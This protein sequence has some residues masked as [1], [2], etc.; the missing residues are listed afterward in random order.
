MKKILI[1]LTLCFAVIQITAQSYEETYLK[2]EK[3]RL[4]KVALVEIE[5][6]NFITQNINTFDFT[7]VINSV[8]TTNKETG[9]PL[10][11][12]DYAT[13]LNTAK[14]QKLRNEYFKK[15]PEKVSLYFA[16]V[17]QQ[18][19]N[20]G[21]EDNGGSTAGYGFASDVYDQST[22]AQYTLTPTTVVNPAP[23]SNV[24]L[25]DAGS[26]DPNIP[27]IP[28]V[29]SGKYAIRLNQPTS[30]LSR[31][32]SLLRRQFIVNERSISYAYAL[33]FQNPADGG[34]TK[35]TRYPY[36]QVRLKNSSGNIVYQRTVDGVSNPIFNYNP[37]NNI[38]Y[39]GWR[40]ENIDTSQYM[41]QF[42]TLEIIMSNCG[43]SGH[44]GYGYFDDFCGLPPN[45]NIPSVG[46]I[47]L[48]PR[49]QTGCPEDPMYITGNYQLPPNATFQMP[50]AGIKLD[51]LEAST[52]N[53]VTTLTSP[54]FPST[55][56]FSFYVSSYS[57]YPSGM[58]SNTEFNFRVR[59]IYNTGG[60]NQ[61]EVSANH[62]NPPGPDV[63]FKNCNSP[64]FEEMYINEK[65]VTSQT[66][67]ASGGIYASSQIY[68]NLEVTYRAGYQ[69]QL[70][71]GFYATG[72]D[73][74][75]FHAY[76]GPCED[77]NTFTKIPPVNSMAKAS[78]T[79]ILPAEIKIHPNPASG[80]FKISTGSEKL[81]SWEM[82]DLSGKMV[83]KG[84]T[85][86]ANVQNLLKGNY[87]LKINLE[88]RQV[89]KT[90]ILK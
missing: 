1:L 37:S 60:I 67:Q 36:Y 35:D 74:G 4:D 26:A 41:G 9:Q 66:F 24:T 19:T 33:F 31:R 65:V 21:F 8:D 45:C 51:I 64:C 30:V 25:V 80:Y 70:L 23:N 39:S 49:S 72:Q 75:I 77:N 40:C 34:H 56:N 73:V 86:D 28:R 87:F 85:S 7:T 6:E 29:Y 68:P 50:G 81:L 47:N 57:F 3:K 32:A 62:T 12:S 43:N 11:A 15:N 38:L 53:L 52:G 5:I 88:K 76:I 42:V 78:E 59:M 18:C 84:T 2:D 20:G 16:Q 89:S 79:Q 83:L 90:V 17:L 44:Y 61:P 22:W 48:H 63:S 27:S 55:N 71:P 13:A 82:Y 46:T 69:I 54:N 10:S 58:T 14:R